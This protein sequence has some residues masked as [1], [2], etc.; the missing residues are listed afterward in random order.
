MGTSLLIG[1]P[2]AL[3]YV[4]SMIRQGEAPQLIIWG[5]LAT[6]AFRVIAAWIYASANRSLVAATIAHA[7][8]TT[9]WIGLLG[10]CQGHELG[11]SISD[12]IIILAALVITAPWGLRT[13]RRQGLCERPPP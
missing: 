12:P 1:V 7:V 11:G 4:P 6:V 9:T 5:L 13:A 10:G 8:G 3:W 2:W